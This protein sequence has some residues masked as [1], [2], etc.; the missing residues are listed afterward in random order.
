MNKQDLLNIGIEKLKNKEYDEALDFLERA[1]EV[2]PEN[3]DIEYNIGQVYM[4]INSLNDALESFQNSIALIYNTCDI[5]LENKKIV[6][7]QIAIAQCYLKEKSFDLCFANCIQIDKS[8]CPSNIELIEIYLV[9]ANELFNIGKKEKTLKLLDELQ[10]FDFEREQDIKFQNLKEKVSKDINNFALL[11]KLTKDELIEEGRNKWSNGENELA[12]Q[13][14]NEVIKRDSKDAVP[15]IDIGKV[16]SS[17]GNYEESIEYFNRALEMEYP[18]KYYVYDQIAATLYEMKKYEKSIEYYDLAIETNSGTIG[19]YYWGK[20]NSFY[21]L[22]KYEE[23]IKH[24]TGVLE[25]ENSS[26]SAKYNAIKFIYLS[27]KYSGKES[28]QIQFLNEELNRKSSPHYYIYELLA[29]KYYNLKN[30]NKS[31]EY[32]DNAISTCLNDKPK[33]HLWKA[34]AHEEIGEYSDAISEYLYVLN[35]PN[36]TINEKNDAVRW[37]SVSYKN[38]NGYDKALDFL[39]NADEKNSCEK[40]VIYDSIGNLYYCLKKFN[41]AE[42]YLKLAIKESH[43]KKGNYSLGLADVYFHLGKYEK[44]L[45]FAEISINEGNMPDECIE[46]AKEFIKLSKN[47]IKE[48]NSFDIN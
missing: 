5:E 39:K 20:A 8:L 23:A 37:I 17:Q 7:A 4:S 26:E 43:N 38:V 24:Y 2:E 42:K 47:K 19:N 13:F 29:E 12:I 48:N 16:L 35:N 1:K 14:F 10:H 41:D 45:E 25:N 33:L 6:S 44:S 32:Y 34:H 40:D 9:L 36:S 22:G 3:P 21:M 30:Y 11:N 27:F 15:I 31:I 18:Y 28:D 46:K